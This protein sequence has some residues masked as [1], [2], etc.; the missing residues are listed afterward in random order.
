M[1][2][3]EENFYLRESEWKREGERAKTAKS[4]LKGIEKGVV[5]ALEMAKS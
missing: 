2:V 4:V 3:A 5:V 1:N